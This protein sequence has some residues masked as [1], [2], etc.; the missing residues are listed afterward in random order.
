MSDCLNQ[1][2]KT[3]ALERPSLSAAMKRPLFMILLALVS[4]PFAFFSGCL[5]A[6]FISPC[7][8]TASK[9]ARIGV[10]LSLPGSVDYLIVF[11][12]SAL[13]L[14]VLAYFVMMRLI[15]GRCRVSHINWATAGSVFG[16]W[17]LYALFN[18]V[19]PDDFREIFYA[20]HPHHPNSVGGFGQG[21]AVYGMFI[22][23]RY[24]ALA[25]VIGWFSGRLAFNFLSGSP[26]AVRS[27]GP[28]AP[29]LAALAFALWSHIEFFASLIPAPPAPHHSP[30]NKWALIED[31]KNDALYY[32]PAS[33]TK[34]GEIYSVR[35]LLEYK[36]PAPIAGK[37]VR[38]ST[39]TYEINCKEQKHLEK[40]SMNL[41]DGRWGSGNIVSDY[42]YLS[43]GGGLPFGI[44]VYN[45]ICK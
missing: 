14:G 9:L 16:L 39:L 6:L 30:D 4:F 40:G 23:P 15:V 8:E 43:E 18:F 25:A 19:A 1:G 34:Y 32:E 36:Y 17:I 13:P 12:L 22:L 42:P 11:L 24:A 27:L 29:L 20:C 28:L 45:F 33:V 7:P 3:T 38:S 41:Y 21:I 26:S 2:D 35:V 37:M 10:A 5:I 31:D 44:T